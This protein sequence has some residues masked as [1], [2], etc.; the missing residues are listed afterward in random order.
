MD[1][2]LARAE[3]HF[4][5]AVPRSV[6]VIDLETR[7]AFAALSALARDPRNARKLL[8][9]LVNLSPPRVIGSLPALMRYLRDEEPDAMFSA[10]DYSNITAI[11]ARHLTGVRTRLVVSVQNT[12]SAKVGLASSR[13]LRSL[14]C[15]I[16]HFYPWA[17]AIA[18]VSD[19]VSDDLARTTGLPRASIHTTYNP[20]VTPELMRAAAQPVDHPWFAPGEPQVVLGIGKLKPQKD[21]PSLLRAFAKVG[22]RRAVRL[23]ILGEG[24]QRRDLCALAASLGV[25]GDLSLPGFVPNPFA[26]LARSAVFA[27]SS[28]VE[29][30]PSVRIEALACGCPVVSTACPSG[31]AEILDRGRYGPLVPVNDP[32]SLAGAICAVLDKPP[33]RERLRERAQLFSAS[34]VADRVGRLLLGDQPAFDVGRAVNP[35]G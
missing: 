12:L 17:D 6:R 31:P 8:P 14:P 7:T 24:P 9:A 15:L 29:G 22:E 3:G 10:L 16:R 18:T 28:A 32:D 26:Y 33:D 19:G 34:H 35:R 13:R 27:L 20:M 5:D 11:W 1:L 25:E 2:V 30:R 21:F 4:L 23:V